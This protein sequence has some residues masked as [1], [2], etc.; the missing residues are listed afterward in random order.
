ME[1][2]EYANSTVV[3]LTNKEAIDIC[4]LGEGSKC[5]AFL[6]CGGLGFEC[7]KQSSMRHHILKRLQANTINAQGTGG[8]KNCAWEKE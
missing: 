2:M 5:C 7:A 6:V 4:H 3:G 1:R 8:W